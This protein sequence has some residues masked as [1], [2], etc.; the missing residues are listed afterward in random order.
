MRHE[1]HAKRLCSLTLPRRP[2]AS[3]TNTWREPAAKFFK[4][5]IIVG[6]DL[7]VV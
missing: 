5:E 3:A 1:Q 4:N 7:M 6:K 2:T